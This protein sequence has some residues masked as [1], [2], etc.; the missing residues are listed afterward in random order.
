MKGRLWAELAAQYDG[1]DRWYLEALGIGADAGKAV[2][3]ASQT[4]VRRTKRPA[5]AC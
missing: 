3:K 4:F 5:R 2:V 1:H